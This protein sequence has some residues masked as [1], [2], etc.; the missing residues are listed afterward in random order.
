MTNKQIITDGVDVSGCIVFNNKYRTALCNHTDDIRE[1]IHCNDSPNCLYKKFKRKEQ[2]CEELKEQLTI[3]DDEA[4]VVEITIKQFEEYKKLKAENEE[5]KEIN[6]ELLK[7]R[8]HSTTCQEC[9]EDG[10]EDGKTSNKELRKL[11]KTLAEIKEIAEKNNKTEEELFKI[12]HSRLT[13]VSMGALTGRCNL[14]REILEKINEC[15]VE[16]ENN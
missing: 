11:R 5:L 12:R 13:K 3:L 15:E 4:V 9:Y 16:D 10:L 14:A 1:A 2:E 6:Q 8:K 7:Y